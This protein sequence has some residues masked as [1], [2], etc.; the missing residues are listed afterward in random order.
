MR[1]KN[2]FYGMFLRCSDKYR[3]PTFLID[4]RRIRPFMSTLHH[5][6]HVTVGGYI[7][8]EMA[9]QWFGSLVTMKWWNDLWL[10]EGFA[11]YMQY[12][13]M[14]ALSQEDEHHAG[15][16]SV[17]HV[18]NFFVT[19]QRRALY[20]DADVSSHPLD[21]DAQSLAEIEELFDEEMNRTLG[22]GLLFVV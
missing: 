4:F 2:G 5:H 9:Q 16:E 1:T 6:H 13:G 3:L 7:S 19:A 15:K 14:D 18:G 22:V 10:S 17:A 12:I 8:H 11:T 20:V 21:S